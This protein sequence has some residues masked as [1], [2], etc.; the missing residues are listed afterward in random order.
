MPEFIIIY[1]KKVNAKN[2]K[3]AIKKEAKIKAKFDS[4]R[5]ESNEE[6]SIIGF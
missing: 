4:I 1:T 2:I 6:I 5:E 3:E